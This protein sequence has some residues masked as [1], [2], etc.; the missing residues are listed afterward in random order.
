MFRKLPLLFLKY[1]DL[2]SN[3]AACL[4]TMQVISVGTLTKIQVNNLPHPLPLQ[5]MLCFDN[6]MHIYTKK[7]YLPTV[8]NIVLGGGGGGGGDYVQIKPLKITIVVL[9]DSLVIFLDGFH[10]CPNYL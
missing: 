8:V 10:K 6:Q 9:N 2:K 1:D 5:A 4:P 7:N 3:F